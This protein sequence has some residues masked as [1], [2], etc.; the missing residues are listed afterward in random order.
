MNVSTSSTCALSSITSVS[1]CRRC[2][3]KEWRLM[4]A[5]VHVIAMIRAWCVMRYADRSRYERSSSK[6]R[7]SSTSSK[8]RLQVREARQRHANVGCERRR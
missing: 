6:G 5:C 4:A 1:Y 3:M 7:H 2:A 8:H